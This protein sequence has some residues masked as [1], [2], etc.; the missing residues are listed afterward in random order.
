MVLFEYGRTH[1]EPADVEAQS[2]KQVSPPAVKLG[3]IVHVWSRNLSRLESNYRSVSKF[4][5][6]QIPDCVD[7]NLCTGETELELACS[8]R[9]AL[10]A[11][12]PGN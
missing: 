2:V 11:L 1:R 8:V 5:Q 4:E 9:S 12:S 10:L 3:F 7:M 6:S